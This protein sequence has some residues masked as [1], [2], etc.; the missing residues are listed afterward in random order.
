MCRRRKEGVI[1]GSLLLTADPEKYHLSSVIFP[2]LA[3]MIHRVLDRIEFGQGRILFFARPSCDEI[4]GAAT[5]DRIC[6]ALWA[7]RRWYADDMVGNVDGRKSFGSEF[8]KGCGVIRSEVRNHSA[9]N[10]LPR[11]Q[12]TDSLD[13]CSPARVPGYCTTTNHRDSSTIRILSPL[14]LSAPCFLLPTSCF[15]TSTDFSAI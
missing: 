14:L 15:H 10:K 3:E 12:C 2:I 11:D 4:N 5:S 9:L 7:A 8:W 6:P 13:Q 1:R